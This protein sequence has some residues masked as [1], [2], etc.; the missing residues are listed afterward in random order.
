M[1]E[2]SINIHDLEWREAE[3]YPGGTLEK[4]LHGSSDEIP[5]TS[6]LKFRPGWEMEAHA[7]VFTEIHYVLEGEYES[8]GQVYP[9]GTFRLIP[10][11]TNH[12]P[13]RTRT[14]ATILVVWAEFHE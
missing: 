4:G 13:F 14:G 12:G 1:N 2:I 11:G 7:H 3:G 5:R 6:V 9:A 8:Q 10:K